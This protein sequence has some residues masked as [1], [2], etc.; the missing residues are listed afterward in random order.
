MNDVKGMEEDFL[1]YSHRSM[2]DLEDAD[3]DMLKRGRNLDEIRSMCNTEDARLIGLI[4]EQQDFLNSSRKR[5]MGRIEDL[6]YYSKEK[7]KEFEMRQEDKHN[8]VKEDKEQYDK[9]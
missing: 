7:V 1:V 3:Y 4:E 8:Q 6:E 2:E 9:E 5:R